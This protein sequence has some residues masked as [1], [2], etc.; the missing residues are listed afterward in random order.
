M[1]DAEDDEQAK[2]AEKR[3]KLAEKQRLDREA[4]DR[5]IAQADAQTEDWNN[6]VSSPTRGRGSR[7]PLIHI[8]AEFP[9]PDRIE[10]PEEIQARIQ[11]S[12][13]AGKERELG[14]A[15]LW[16]TVEAT[17]A[18]RERVERGE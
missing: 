18:E 9:D 2:L 13:D 4:A 8:P 14:L 6:W 12:V 17:R 7:G 16:A 1:E 3:A 15:N 5:I 10:T 11:A